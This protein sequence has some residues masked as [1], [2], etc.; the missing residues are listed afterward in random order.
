MKNRNIFIALALFAG[1]S[2]CDDWIDKSPLSDITEENY[3]RTET[4]LQ[5]FSNGFY[6]SILNKSPY[7]EQSDV[8][9]Q[10]ELSDEMLGGEN[11][12]VP[13]SGGGW[14]WTALRSVNT[15]LGNVDKCEDAEAAVKYTA[16]A[17]FFRAYFYYDKV[18]RF[19]D[20]PWYDKELFS[21]DPDLYKARDSRELVMTNMLADIDYAIENLPTKE[22]ETSSPFRVN[23]WAALALKSRFCLYEGTYRKYHNLTLEGHDYAYY[24]QQAA[25]AAE[26]LINSGEY[27]LYSTDNPEEDYLML[28]AEE[29]ANPDE[30]ILA[31]KFDYG[32]DP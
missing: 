23:R 6:N 32:I 2:S 1:L 9:V 29:D 13:A 14:S 20:V 26:E 5:L 31:I 27:H 21:D 11:R 4:D 22:E 10:Q 16:L 30:Y 8:Y 7:D 12:I 28:F 24:L 15:L 17:R 3:F 18:K 19:G 25:D